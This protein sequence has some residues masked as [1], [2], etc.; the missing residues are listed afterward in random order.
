MIT[1]ICVFGM[2]AN[3]ACNIV[4]GVAS[5]NCS[6]VN[7]NII[8][9]PKNYEVSG[10]RHFDGIVGSISVR[11]GGNVTI[12]GIASAATVYAGGV[13]QVTGQTDMIINHGGSVTVDGMVQQIQS[14]GGTVYVSGV[15]SSLMGSGEFHFSDGAHVNGRW[16]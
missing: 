9:R 12:S 14:K 3:A 2:Q 11:K 5:G 13:L 4:N 15:V 7:I 6:G 8:K 1:A 10:Y 16:Y